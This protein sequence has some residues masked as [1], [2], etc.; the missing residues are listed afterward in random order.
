M[1]AFT[2]CALA[3]MPHT[4][5]HILPAL[6]YAAFRWV[7]ENGGTRIVAIG[8][9]EVLDIYLKVGL[10][11]LGRQIRSGAVTFE[12]ITATTAEVHEHLVRYAPLLRRLERHVD[13][14]LGIPFAESAFE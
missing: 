2:S 5:A 8:R 11:A 4:G 13:W 9:R 7:E 10:R 14:Q 3:V 6:I 12:L 1:I